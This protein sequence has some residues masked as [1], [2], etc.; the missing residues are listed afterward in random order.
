MIYQ[1]KSIQTL[2][3]NDTMIMSIQFQGH[4]ANSSVEYL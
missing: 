4:P 2:K 3:N 1:G